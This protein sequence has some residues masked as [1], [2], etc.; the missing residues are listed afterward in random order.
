MFGWRLPVLGQAVHVWYAN[1]G[2]HATSSLF[3]VTDS[4]AHKKFAPWILAKLHLK[5]SQLLIVSRLS[6]AQSGSKSLGSDLLK[7]VKEMK[8]RL[9]LVRTHWV[10]YWIILSNE[11]RSF[12]VLFLPLSGV[13]LQSPILCHH[14]SHLFPCSCSSFS[15]PV[16]PSWTINHQFWPYSQPS[17]TLFLLQ[18]YKPLVWN[19]CYVIF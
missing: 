6:Y 14:F 8:Q 4:L 1:N 3:R 16:C 2:C 19:Q 12:I 13:S 11:F 9:F 18:L 17:L 10:W 7:E 15:F 5:Q